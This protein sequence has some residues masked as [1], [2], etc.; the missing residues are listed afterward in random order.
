ML[1]RALRGPFVWGC[2]SVAVA[3]VIAPLTSTSANGEEVVEIATRPG[4]SV[5]ALIDKPAKSIGSV[6]LLVGGHGNLNLT[7]DGKIGWGAGN[8]V[9]RTRAAYAAKG[10]VALVPDIAPD[11]KNGEKVQPGYRWSAKHATDI[12]ALVRHL[13]SIAA[14]VYLVGTSRAAL[15]VANAATRLKGEERPDAIVITSGMIASAKVKQPFA[16]TKVGRLERITQPVLLVYH[17]KDG[18]AYTPASSGQRA[19]SLFKGAKRVD[20]KILSGGEDGGGDPCKAQTHHG[21]L[22]QDAEVVDLVTEWLKTS[23]AK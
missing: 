7:M 11:L 9:V 13:R 19:K 5:R 20:L 15:S 21:F 10:F 14:P 16:E 4:Q 23:G 1:C 12:G 3:M 8:Q 2:L 22:G 17:E 6:I 18:C